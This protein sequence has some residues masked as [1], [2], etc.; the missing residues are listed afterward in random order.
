MRGDA[1]MPDPRKIRITVGLEK[2]QYEA[3]AAL[4]EEEQRSLSWMAAQAVK[5][6]LESRE[7]QY[8]LEFERPKAKR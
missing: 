1:L 4:A 6:F 7:R 3:L 2:P 8:P 5:Q